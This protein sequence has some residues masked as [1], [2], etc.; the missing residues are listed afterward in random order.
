MDVYRCVYRCVCIGVCISVS[1]DVYI[2]AY[3]DLCTYVYICI[4]M[5]VEKAGKDRRCPL[6][7]GLW[8]NSSPACR[9][10]TDGMGRLL[11]Y[12]A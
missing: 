12:G 3:I 8:H 1:M 6:P 11:D 10:L 2:D 7:M 5:G 4:Q 9:L